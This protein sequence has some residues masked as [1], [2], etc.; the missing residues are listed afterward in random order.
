MRLIL[1]LS[2]LRLVLIVLNVI[3]FGYLFGVG[4][5]ITIPMQATAIQPLHGAAY[6]FSGHVLL[7]GSVD[8]A[9]NTDRGSASDITI[10]ED[11]R[12]LTPGHA[13]FSQIMTEGAGAH[14]YRPGRLIFS[15]SDNSDPS[16]NG[17]SYSLHTQLRPG[18]R[19]LCCVLALGLGVAASIWAC[20]LVRRRHRLPAPGATMAAL[21]RGAWIMAAGVLAICVTYLLAEWVW[22]AMVWL[23]TG[24]VLTLGVQAARQFLIAH[25]LERGKMLPWEGLTNLSVVIVSVSIVFAAAEIGL[26]WFAVAPTVGA[27]AQGGDRIIQTGV[28]RV[29]LPGAL[30][31]DMAARQRGTLLPA[32]WKLTLLPES[33]GTRAFRWHGIVHTEDQRGFRRLNGPFPAKLPG[34]PRIVVLGDSLTYGEGI[35]LNHTY[36]RVLADILSHDHPVEVLNLG[37]RGAQSED[38]LLTA[39]WALDQLQPDLVVYG[40][41]LNDFLPSGVGQTNGGFVWPIPSRYQDWVMRQTLSAPMIWSGYQ[42]LA[43]G[44]HLMSD[45]HDDIRRGDHEFQPRFASDMRMINREVTAR[46]L[47]PV[48]ATVL[49]IV[50][51]PG[52]SGQQL[53]RI[54]EAAMRQAGMTVVPGADFYARYA[55]QEFQ[56]SPWEGHPN[57]AANAIF[58]TRIADAIQAQRWL[59]P[60]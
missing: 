23:T 39:L 36:P 19:L 3:G 2:P 16:R 24:L 48:L 17:R 44:L 15:T 54:A 10:R 12:A 4:I 35:A 42:K 33:N 56:V 26:S 27:G 59:M 55:G 1:T 53:A 30:V 32:S 18:W 13:Q 5:P 25:G 31:A 40:M 60:R 34:R 14:A 20:R 37:V 46:G 29:V 38:I 57:E 51:Q 6:L 49:D 58:A 28:A 9:D 45:F 47:P 22:G 52:G 43:I 50:P 11:G 7:S 21:R 8:W 41:C